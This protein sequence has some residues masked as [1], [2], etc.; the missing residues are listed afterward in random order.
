MGAD[1]KPVVETPTYNVNVLLYIVLLRPIS[2]MSPAL[3]P[4]H[5]GIKV[6]YLSEYDTGNM[7]Y[8]FQP[9]ISEVWHLEN[10]V[11]QL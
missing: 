7:K 8:G 5:Q 11:H 2:L 1:L 3:T 9:H 4:L 6:I 10:I